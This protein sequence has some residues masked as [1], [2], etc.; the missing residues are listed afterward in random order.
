MYIAA[1]T[2]TG[3][4]SDE[5]FPGGGYVFVPEANAYMKLRISVKECLWLR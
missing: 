2:Q 3:R 1:A 4:T 5:E